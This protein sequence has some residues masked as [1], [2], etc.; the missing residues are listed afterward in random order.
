M[1]YTTSNLATYLEVALGSTK[2]H[3]Q[4]GGIPNTVISL[5]LL[6]HVSMVN[7]RD[8][9]MFINLPDRW[10]TN[11]TTL[12]LVLPRRGIRRHIISAPG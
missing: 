11:H 7:E 1:N 3:R 5:V 8:P 2:H 9:S 10:P 4:D 12:G 6:D